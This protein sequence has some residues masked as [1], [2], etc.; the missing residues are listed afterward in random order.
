[1][2]VPNGFSMRTCSTKPLCQILISKTVV[3]SI[4]FSLYLKG[5]KFREISKDMLVQV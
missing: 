2:D 4:Q 1:M 3:E 5:N